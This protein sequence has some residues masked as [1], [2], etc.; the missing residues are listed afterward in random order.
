M[1]LVHGAKRVIVM[2]EHTAKGGAHKI[3]EQCTLPLTGARVVHQ[4]IT[5]MATIDV[6]PDGLVLRELAPGV[7]LDDVRTATGAPLHVPRDPAEMSVPPV[8]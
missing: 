5:D 6:T 7:S 8:P 3:L 2:M 1:D 4:I